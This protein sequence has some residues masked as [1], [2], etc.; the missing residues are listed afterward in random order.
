MNSRH[1][2]VLVVDDQPDNIDILVDTLGSE[3]RIRAATSGEQALRLVGKAPPDLILLDIMMPVMDG[4]EVCR[5]LKQDYTTRHIPV[6]FVTAMISADDERK[7]L[8]LGAVDY[9]TKPI[10]PSVVRARVATHLA[11]YDQNRELDRKVLQQTSAL[12][13]A[14]LQLVHRLGRAAEFKDYET[15][16]HVVRMSK[17]AH[18]LALEAGMSETD[19]DTLL[20]A[21]PMH[22]IGKIGIPDHILQKAGRLDEEEWKIMKTHCEIGAEIIGDDDGELLGMARVIALSHHEKWDGSG[23]PAG[24][25]GEQIPLV[26]RIVAIADVFDALTTSRP[27]KKA[28]S[29]GEA[30]EHLQKG[31]GQH[32]DPDLVPLFIGLED[33]LIEIHQRYRDRED[34]S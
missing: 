18:L 3:Y 26:G 33:S 10:S 8:D 11:L 9:I 32:F 19:A 16:M 17:Y 31:A 22:D 29:I 25:A 7:G 34:R 5:K 13:E 2:S 20:H 6:I 27:Y 1:Y 30:F 23:Y 14:R 4:F 15:G 12:N 28:W 21:A 24:L